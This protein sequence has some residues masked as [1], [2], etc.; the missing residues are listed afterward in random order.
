MSGGRC[1]VAAA[2]ARAISAA[3]ARIAS[4]DRLVER[5]LVDPAGGG[6]PSVRALAITSGTVA[7]SSSMMSKASCAFRRTWSV[8]GTGAGVADHVVEAIDQLE[9]LHRIHRPER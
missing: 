4:G 9:D 6:S 1:G 8:S 2:T 7:R 3:L 5:L